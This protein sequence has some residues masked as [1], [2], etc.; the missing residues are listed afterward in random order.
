VDYYV[1][2]SLEGFSQMIDALGGIQL[3]VNTYIPIGG[4]SDLGIPPKEFLK[5]GPDQKLKGHDALWYARGRYGFSDFDRMDRQRCV[6]NAIIKQ[7]NPTNMLARYEDIAKAGKQLVRTDMPQEV[8]PLMVDLSLR[9]K[10][11]NVRSIVFKHGES[12]FYSTNPDFSRMRKRVKTALGESK[13]NT[14]AAPKTPKKS[15][16]R[17]PQSEDVNDTCAYDPKVAETSRPYR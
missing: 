10:D 8:L 14:E 13:N 1:L 12:G 2:I 17:S 16:A 3:N 4:N 15:K 7:A 5:P 11:G 6:I 9:V